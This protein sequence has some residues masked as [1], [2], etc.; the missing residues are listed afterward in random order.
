MLALKPAKSVKDTIFYGGGGGIYIYIE[1]ERERRK[2]KEI[3]VGVREGAMLL[4][5]S[6]SLSWKSP[7]ALRRLNQL[8]FWEQP[9]VT[10]Q[11]RQM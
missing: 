1:R 9:G 5:Y 11:G 10:T 3:Q 6:L 7:R 4:T 2:E 8:V